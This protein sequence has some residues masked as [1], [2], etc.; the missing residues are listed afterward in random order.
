MREAGPHA[1]TGNEGVGGGVGDPGQSGLRMERYIYRV[2]IVP[3]RVHQPNKLPTR[4]WRR[5]RLDG[6]GR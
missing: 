2:A 5:A 4:P 6:Q 3:W 1:R